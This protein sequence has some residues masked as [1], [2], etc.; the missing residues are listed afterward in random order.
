MVE[1]KPSLPF[2]DPHSYFLSRWF[3]LRLLGIVY[4]IAF[5]SIWT[6][7]PGLIGSDGILPADRF[8]EMVKF[9]LGSKAYRLIPTL[10]WFSAHDGFLQFLALGG[11]LL[12]VLAILGMLTVPVLVLLWIFYLSLVSAGGVFMSFQWDSLLLEVGFLAIF[13]APLQVLPRFSSGYPPSS[14]VLWLFRL[15]LFRLM[16]SSGLGKLSSGDPTWRNFTALDFHYFTQPLPT[17][18]AWYMYQLPEWFHKLSVGLMF[19]VELV[20]P[21]L[22]FAP[23]QIRFHAGAGII[24]LQVFIALTGNYTFFNLLTITLCVLLFDDTLV[25]RLVPTRLTEAIGL[26]R[27]LPE[28]KNRGLHKRLGIGILALIIAFLGA[29]QLSSVI[30]GSQNMPRILQEIFLWVAPFRIVNN[31]GLFRV[32]TTSRS[33]IVIEGSRDG[34]NWVEYEFKYKPVDTRRAPSWVAP[35]QP[36]LDWQMWF[37]ALGT[38]QNNPWFVNFMERILRGSPDVLSLLERDPFAGDAPRYVRGMLYQYRFSDLHTKRTTGE[39]WQRDLIGTYFYPISSNG[40]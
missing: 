16:F 12:S 1:N 33:E 17:P 8:L 24:L 9:N 4:L 25:R 18:L 10:A 6:Q 37:A 7:L 28:P 11:A 2:L 35:H 34:E 27:P 15:L 20:I 21:F 31:Y 30:V 14:I 40:D 38:T 19:F 39:W 3:F 13:I 36:R 23:R 22:I 5:F 32:M 26:S 29:I